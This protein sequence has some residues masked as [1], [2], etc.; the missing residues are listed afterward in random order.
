MSFSAQL[1]AAIAAV[2]TSAQIDNLSRELWAAYAAGLLDDD[3]AQAATEL[4]HARRRS[5]RGD[6]RPQARKAF[7]APPKR[8]AAPRSPDRA[9]SIARR[10]ACATSGAVPSR[11]ACQFTTGETAVLAVIAGE[12]RERGAC[13]LPIDALG[14][15]SGTSR[16]V[17]KRALREAKALGIITVTER[18]RPGQ[19]HLPNVVKIVSPEWRAWDRGPARDRLGNST[20]KKGPAERESTGKGLSERRIFEAPPSRPYSRASEGRCERL[21]AALA[22]SAALL[23]PR[24]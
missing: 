4:L 10:R 17:V 15:L 16:S 14:A 21:D 13:S 2:K 20:C 6:P 12:V 11:I 24:R 5:L 22:R 19:K 23:A 3:A 9:K 18:P 1:S 7:C 8:R